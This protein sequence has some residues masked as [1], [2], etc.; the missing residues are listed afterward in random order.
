LTH[1]EEL[2]RVDIDAALR[3]AGWDVQDVAQ[4]NLFTARGVA[5]REFPLE[6]GYG[7]ADYLLYVDGK[8]AGVIEAKPAGTTLTGAEPQS[9]RYARGVSEAVP[10]AYRPLPFIYQSTGVETRFTNEIDP[11]PRSRRVFHFHR[12]ATFAEWLAAEPRVPPDDR[13]STLRRRLCAMPP[14]D[15]SGLW[16]AQGRAVRGLEASLAEDQPRALIQMATGTGKTYTAVHAAYRLIKHANA[17]RILFLVDR[18]TLGKQAYGEFVHFAPAGEGRTFGQEFNIQHLVS[19][20]LDPVARVVITT[21]QRVYSMLRGDTDLDPSLEEGSQFDTGGG[22]VREPVPVAYNPGLPVE[23]FDVLFIDECHRSIY[24]L[25][26]QVLEYFDAHLIGLTATPSKQTFGFFNQNLV[27]EYGH[28]QAVA[29]GVNVDFDVYRIRTRITERGSTVEAGPFEVVGKRDRETRALRWERLDEDLSYDA[30]ALD[31]QVVAVDQIRTVFQAFKDRLFTDIFPGRTEVPKTLIF[32]KDDSHADDIVQVVREVFGKGNEFAQKITYRTWMTGQKPE[33]LLASFR[34]SYFPRIAVTVD[35]VATGTDIRPLE[36]VMFMR[37]VKSR[38]FFEQM[39][40]RG[41]R[42]ISDTDL[43]AVTPDAGSKDH[44]VIVD[45]VGVCEQPLSETY[46]LERRR[47]VSFERLLQ[48]VAF[49]STDPDALSSLAG[50]LARLDHRLGQPERNVLAT[51]AG[52]TTLKEIA[53][54]IVEALDADRQADEARRAAG[55]PSSAPSTAEQ[56]AQAAERLLKSAAAPLA[57]NPA[58]RERLI[59][60]KRSFEQTIDTA[61]K[62]EVT[63]AAYSAEAKDK[64]KHLVVSFE[65]FIRAHHDEITALQVL[66]SVPYG[67]RPTFAEIKALADTIKAPP[68]SWT[69]EVLWRA[70]ETLDRDR[71]RGTARQRLLTD[72]VSLVRFAL[73]QDAALTPF[74]ERVEERFSRWLAEQETRNRGFT[75]EQVEWLTLMRD[76]IAASLQIELDDLDSVP[77]NQ[78]GGAGRAYQVFGSQLRPLLVELNEA[79]AA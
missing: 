51:L 77:F 69:P 62:D 57:G 20:R 6:P 60:L 17:E 46:P 74:K 75:A 39:K 16:P 12:P 31:R 71:V 73:K 24:S 1:P 76:H 22:L 42:V 65:E 4:T 54:S 47:T 67:R 68:R 3:A 66:F 43:Q 10:A 52:G 44:F 19:N 7:H 18:Y 61:S 38:I 63:T 72:L 13:P 35:M 37:A 36:M 21:I 15:D 28:E 45:C 48:T 14:L 26:R 70:Y 59:E 32:A 53:A 9:E 29:D 2:A 49:G 58:L 8:A 50:R 55:L 34:N 78:R 33:D 40:G 23:Y 27:M 5:I 79:L 30:A 56:T 64:A 25:W 11:E 41:V